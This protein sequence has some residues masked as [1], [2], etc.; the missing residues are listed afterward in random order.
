[1]DLPKYKRSNQTG[2]K[3]LNELKIIVEEQLG[4]ILRPNHQEDD[5][6]IDGYLDIIDGE[7]VSGKSIAFQSKTGQSY[8]NELDEN[9]W[10]FRD[11]FEHLNYY[12]NLDIPVLIILVDDVN[13]IVYWEICKGE[14]TS[15]TGQSWT[16]PI[17][18]NQQLNSESKTALRN[19]VSRTVDYTSQLES[20]WD[21]NKLLTDSGHI[22]LIVERDD[23]IDL[24]YDPLIEFLTRACSNKQLLAHLCEKIEIGIHGYDNQTKELHEIE[25]VRIWVRQIFFRVPG[26]TYFLCNHEY[27]Q[28]LKLFMFC[29]IEFDIVPNSQINVGKIIRKKVTFETNQLKNIFTVIFSDLNDFTETFKIDLKINERIS[30]NILK[31]LSGEEIPDE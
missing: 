5:F 9:H 16:I 6:G 27:S 29:Q 17:P 10:L 2:R 11:S 30:K 28:F 12:L 23:I 18:K 13:K 31:C 25:G 4:W 7:N 26:L 20:Y 14:Y 21:G 19:L 3:G 8:L 1:M 15:R 22:L 24:N